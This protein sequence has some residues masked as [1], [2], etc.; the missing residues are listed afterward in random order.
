KA[1]PGYREQPDPA[2]R[3]RRPVD[4]SVV[5]PSSPYARMAEIPPYVSQL[6]EDL[7]YLEQAAEAKLDKLKKPTI[8]L[9]K[10][11]RSASDTIARNHSQLA[12][13]IRHRLN[14]SADAN[15]MVIQQGLAA[16]P[17][18]GQADAKLTA[19]GIESKIQADTV[20]KLGEA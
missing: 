13:Q 8:L 7:S 14:A 19:Q 9:L 15:A 18:L 3:R 1:P 2:K 10:S 16:R 12:T 5:A 17:G 6:T 4:A 20:A 11:I